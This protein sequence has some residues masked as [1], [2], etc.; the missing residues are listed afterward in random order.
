V[1]HSTTASQGAPG[2]PGVAWPV[3]PPPAPGFPTPGHRERPAGLSG[4]AKAVVAAGVLLAGVS[5][6]RLLPDWDEARWWLVSGVG[7]GLAGLLGLLALVGAVGATGEALRRR[8]HI[9]GAAL[10]A[11]LVLVA[12]VV[13]AG[14]ALRA[15]DDW[16]DLDVPAAWDRLGDNLSDPRRDP[17]SDAEAATGGPF[18]S[19][20]RIGDCRHGDADDPGRSVDCD[21]PHTMEV[22][23][24]V[25]LSGLSADLASA[26]RPA[27]AV[28]ACAADTEV[29]RLPDGAVAGAHV[30]EL[31]WDAGLQRAI[32]LALWDEPVAGRRS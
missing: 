11:A 1:Q 30:I 6:A 3:A 16:Y 7:L 20:I 26:D 15:V 23:G 21:L 31:E 2:H 25:D 17:A 14:V 24:V 19:T 13:L 27:A 32:C 9:D 4:A 18:G 5:L 29:E 22:L 12:A 28:S 10:S 8:A